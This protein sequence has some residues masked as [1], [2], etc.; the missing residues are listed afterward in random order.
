MLRWTID[1]HFALILRVH[2][3]VRLF[4]S[5]LSISDTLPLPNA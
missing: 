1:S 3:R 2:V 5:T 4:R